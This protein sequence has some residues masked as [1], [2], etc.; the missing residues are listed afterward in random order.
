MKI[1]VLS[2]PRDKERRKKLFQNFINKSS[3]FLFFEALNKEQAQDI[4]ISKNLK[5]KNTPVPMS[6]SEIAC[7]LGHKAILENMI[8]FNFKFSL[9]LEDD[10]IGTDQDIDKI[11][12]IVTILPEGSILIA[13]GLEGL[14]SLKSLYGFCVNEELKVY[15]IPKLYYRYLARTCCYLISYTVAQQIIEKQKQALERADNWEYL[16][17]QCDHVYYSPILK[18]PIDLENSHI[19]Q[20]RQLMK[21]NGL[22][23][24]II[25]EGVAHSIYYFFRKIILSYWAWCKGY[26]KIKNKE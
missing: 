5:I 2:L 21:G 18:H 26:I 8:H 13:G 12:K 4:F 17:D 19:E 3:E 11:D 6:L 24:S 25:R 9:I 7:S 15:K 16:L 10:V 20:E 22:M 14:K 1:Y 23:I